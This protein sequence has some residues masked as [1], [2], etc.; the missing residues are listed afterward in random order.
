MVGLVV[1]SEYGDVT[2]I[3]HS[4]KESLIVDYAAV[5][6]SETSPASVQVMRE[7]RLIIDD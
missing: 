1:Y 2:Y 6:C 4:A 7:C 5:A 3:V